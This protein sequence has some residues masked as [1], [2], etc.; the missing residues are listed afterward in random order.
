[1][2]IIEVTQQRY[3]GSELLLENWHEF[4]SSQQKFLALAENMLWPI[5]QQLSQLNEVK[6]NPT[7]P[8]SDEQ[9]LRVFR[10]AELHAN[11]LGDFDNRST[12]GWAVDGIKSV[13]RS[14]ADSVKAAGKG[15]ADGIR[16]SADTLK[17]LDQ[18]IDRLGE[19]AQNT[20]P[21]RN[22]DQQFENLKQKIASKNPAIAAKVGY[23]GQW[24]KDNPV[25][26]SLGIAIL[27]AVAA[28]AG[29]PSGGAAVGFLLRATK[30][31]MAGDK[32]SS[33][34]GKGAKAAGLGWLA[35]L[36]I[37]QIQDLFASIAD[38]SVNVLTDKVSRY[39]MSAT[40]DFEQV[41]WMSVTGFQDDINRMKQLFDAFKQVDLD[42]NSQLGSNIV[43]AMYELAEKMKDPQYILR[44]ADE[45]GK[46]EALV[47]S[48]QAFY[49][50]VGV[51]GDAVQ[52]ATTGFVKNKPRASLPEGLFSGKISVRQLKKLWKEYRQ[53]RTVNSIKL[54]LV[55]A[56]FNQ[57]QATAIINEFVSTRTP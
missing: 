29:G 12:V 48:A 28:F 4:D 52:G 17:T 36:T 7:Q 25:K 39:T 37:E 6:L 45:V 9:I 11:T 32:L 41:L 22:I 55:K 16:F 34:V 19:L 56:G 40:R 10:I 5:L 13:G 35:G 3:S 18:T 8:L 33:A 26:A 42:K 1:M 46:R 20:T 21:V 51:L 31:L 30:D 23:V 38:I 47:K 53:P 44:V 2:K 24:M 14:A 49:D 15:V 57:A 27:T 50:F 54:L 43:N